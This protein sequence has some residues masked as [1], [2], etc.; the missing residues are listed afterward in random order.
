MVCK[1]NEILNTLLSEIKILRERISDLEYKVKTL[2][3]KPK[4]IDMNTVL[5]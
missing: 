1:E 5:R 3:E 2:K 4:K